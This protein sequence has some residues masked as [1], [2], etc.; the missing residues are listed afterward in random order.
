AST[1]ICLEE[2]FSQVV[3]G[4]SI[5]IDDYGLFPGCKQATD[6]FFSVHTGVSGPTPVSAGAVVFQKV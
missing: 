1:K 4:G 6:E 3:S 2:L 5:I